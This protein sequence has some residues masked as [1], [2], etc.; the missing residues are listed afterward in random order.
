MSSSTNSP[1]SRASTRRPPTRSRP[2]PA[3]T[4]ARIE[5]ELDARAQGTRRRGRA[6]RRSTGITTADAGHA[7]RERHQDASRISPAAP[8][9]I[10]SAGAS[11]RTARR[12]AT[13][14]FSTASSSPA[15]EAEAMIMAARVKAGWIEAEDAERGRRRRGR[16]RRGRSRAPDRARPVAAWRRTDRAT[17]DEDEPGA[18]CIVDARRRGPPDELIRF[19]AGPDGEVVP[20]L[21]RKLPGRG[22]WVTAPRATWST[23]RCEARLFAR[24][25]KATVEVAADLAERRRR[26]CCAKR[27]CD[28]CRPRQQGRAGGHGLHQGR[29][30]HRPGEAVAALVACR[31]RGRGR[32]QRRSG[33]AVR[34]RF[35]DRADAVRSS[36][37]LEF[38]G[39]GFGIGAAKC[40]TCCASRRAGASRA[41]VWRRLGAVGPASADEAPTMRPEADIERPRLRRGSAGSAE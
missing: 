22:V 5:A 37:S 3:T 4:S 1:R 2:A 41:A 26:R 28:A 36:P 9:T 35:G 21:K 39:I 20:D 29:G 40:D 24:A 15:S 6:A 30:G 8:P 16:G 27:R 34:R 14:A 23:R 11:A 31:G 18:T 12:R 10:S 13:P 19:V 33:Q 17:T 32:R 7:R 38:G 25:C